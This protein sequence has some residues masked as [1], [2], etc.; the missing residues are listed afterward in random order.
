MRIKQIFIRYYSFI[1]LMFVIFQAKANGEELDT[2][3]LK[4]G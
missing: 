4:P 3:D 2:I 1:W